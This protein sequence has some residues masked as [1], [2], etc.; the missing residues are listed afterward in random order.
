MKGETKTHKPR[1]TKMIPIQVV[2]DEMEELG[3]RGRDFL[4]IQF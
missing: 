2:G 4:K 1:L 3:M